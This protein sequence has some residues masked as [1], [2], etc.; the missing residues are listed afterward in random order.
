M[1]LALYIALWILSISLAPVTLWYARKIAMT[2]VENERSSHQ[3]IA[4][5]G[6]GL[7]FILVFYIG[8]IA[9]Y[10]LGLTLPVALWLIIL[11][12]FI[13]AVLSWF[14]D[15]KGLSARIRFGVQLLVVISV[16]WYLPAIDISLP[17]WLSKV[18]TI[19]AWVWFINLFN[20]MDG[21]DGLAAQQGIFMVIMLSILVASLQSTML[22]LLIGLLGF[23]SINYP[24]AKI[25]MGDIG[26]TFLG[27][28]LAG[29]MIYA[30]SMGHLSLLT[31]IAISSFF[32]YDATYTLVKRALQRKKVWQAH[33]EHWYQRLLITGYSH[34]Q[35][36]W[37]AVTYNL[38]LGLVVYFTPVWVGL[39]F[40]LLWFVFYA[41]FICCRE[42]L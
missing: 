17:M 33:R 38:V 34:Q 21:A 11:A 13:I 18:L 37:L 12:G 30:L 41:L 23:L 7:L 35:L 20:F 3:G 32:A 24:K 2:D 15:Y 25:F 1:L 27:F 36:F 29:Y 40:S 26:S 8:V 6:G 19:F 39:V 14:D 31:V 42:A 4:L 10:L 22:I 16:V 5:R 9:L 28:I